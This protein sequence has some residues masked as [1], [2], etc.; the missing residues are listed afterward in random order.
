MLTALTPQSRW[1]S[2]GFS[3]YR[4]ERAGA[5]VE[6]LLTLPILMGLFYGT[7]SLGFTIFT[8]QKNS[9]VSREIGNLILRRCGD[10]SSETLLF[11]C[12]QP[13]AAELLAISPQ[14]LGPNPRVYMR[15][16]R[17]SFH[18][19][20]ECT[21][22]P[23]SY[24]GNGWED[25]DANY[26]DSP[27]QCEQGSPS[28]ACT[29]GESLVYNPNLPEGD[30]VMG[31]IVLEGGSIIWNPPPGQLYPDIWAGPETANDKAALA[32]RRFWRGHSGGS[33]NRDL[34]IQRGY[35]IEVEIHTDY[36]EPRP[37]KYGNTEA[38]ERSIF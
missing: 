21:N 18:S 11:S 34:L 38:R 19:C 7:L 26:L 28:C 33:A 27:T 10:L 15:Y 35:A 4:R 14:L 29:C 12:I 13:S 2:N 8:Q 24:D 1:E 6:F 5:I 20:I 16:G 22:P 9:A 37:W 25:V 32:R 3:A 23:C 30:L 31:G 17:C 36:F